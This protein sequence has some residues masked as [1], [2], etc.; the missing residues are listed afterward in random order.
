M[1]R[2]RSREG[3]NNLESSSRDL[4]GRRKEKERVSGR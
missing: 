2:K 1:G 4:M 3:E